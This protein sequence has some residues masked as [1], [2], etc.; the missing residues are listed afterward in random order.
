M[1]D[2]ASNIVNVQGEI[3]RAARDV[4]RHPREITLVAVSKTRGVTEISAAA[5][6]G[7][8][9]FGENYLQEAIPKIEAL[10]ERGLQWHY[11]GRIQSNKTAG[12]ARH[13]DWVQTLDR[14]KHA[15]RL[16]EQRPENRRPLNVCIQVNISGETRKG[17][18]EPDGVTQLAQ[19]VLGLPRLQL[20]GLMG[21]AA[22]TGDETRIAH[23]FDQLL[24][25]FMELQRNVRSLDTLSMGMSGD[26]RV[27]IRCGASML[28]IG[29]A[30]FG[31]RA[32]SAPRNDHEG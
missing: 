31:E 28:R 4:H 20:R 21:M 27:A 19:A 1:T 12:I 17:G 32:Y 30:I 8:R 3:S 25:A 26:F 29:S 23:S 18:V 5:D 15:R 6:A 16:N 2:V 7:L 14:E 9:H 11:I 24:G 10:A 22:A 13:F